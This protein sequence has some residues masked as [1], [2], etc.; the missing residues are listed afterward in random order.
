MPQDKHQITKHPASQFPHLMHLMCK[1]T[2][3]DHINRGA[4]QEVSNETAFPSIVTKWDFLAI[5]NLIVRIRSGL[6]LVRLLTP[7]QTSA[8]TS[9]CTR[10]NAESTSTSPDRETRIALSGAATTDRASLLATS[11]PE[12]HSASAPNPDVCPEFDPDRTATLCDR[13]TLERIHEPRRV[14]QH[15]SCAHSTAA[16]EAGGEYNLR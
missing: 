11:K 16:V 2:E 7:P 6:R 4:K 13:V 5:G 9:C 8:T 3:R 15:H 12:R 10:S 14:E 1:W